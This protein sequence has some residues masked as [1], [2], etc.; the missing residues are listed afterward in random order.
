MIDYDFIIISDET[1]YNLEDGPEDG[2]FVFGLY[3]EGARWDENLEAIEESHPKVLFSS[4]KSIWIL[5][6]KK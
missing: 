4:M 1:K 5:P 6:A 3:M 2:I